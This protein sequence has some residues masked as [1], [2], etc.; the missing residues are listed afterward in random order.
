MRKAQHTGSCITA[1]D[2]RHMMPDVLVVHRH[3]RT[4]NASVSK[5]SDKVR[6]PSTR[7][8]AAAHT[9][10]LTAVQPVSLKASGFDQRQ[11]PHPR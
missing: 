2:H 6:L 11:Q 9:H 8:A 1:H 4:I 3:S 5:V 10:G 7:A